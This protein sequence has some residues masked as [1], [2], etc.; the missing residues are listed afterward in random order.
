[1]AIKVWDYLAEYK[2]EHD[3]IMQGIEK[4]LALGCLILGESVKKFEREFSAYCDAKYGVGVDNATNG[5]F[6]SMKALGIGQGD[7]VITVLN[8]VVPTVSAIAATGALPRF[9]D[10]DAKT[11]LMDV[12]LL[13]KLSRKE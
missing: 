9:V 7:E 10:I 4:V 8:T 12:S 11:Y 5:L 3:D 6:L 2:E 1:M 13:E